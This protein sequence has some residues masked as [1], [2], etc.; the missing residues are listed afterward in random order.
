MPSIDEDEQETSALEDT[1]RRSKADQ[2]VRFQEHVHVIIPPPRTTL[3]SREAGTYFIFIVLFSGPLRICPLRHRRCQLL[4]EYVFAIF[5]EFEPDS[6]DLEDDAVARA[7]WNML[8]GAGTS[9]RAVDASTR[10]AARRFGR[11]SMDIPMGVD[12]TPGCSDVDMDDLVVRQAA[13]GRMLN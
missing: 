8:S 13:G 2:T 1:H 5:I 7:I 12:T 10:W 9:T 11:R 4:R 3:K 6:D